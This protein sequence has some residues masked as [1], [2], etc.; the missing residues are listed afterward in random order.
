MFQNLSSFFKEFDY[1]NG[2]KIYKYDN[3]SLKMLQ[4][5]YQIALKNK[6]IH[7]SKTILKDGKI[8]D[9]ED[10]TRERG[11]VYWIDFGINIG[12]EFNSNHFGVVIKEFKYTALV[13][14]I[15]TIK[16]SD[17]SWKN[18]EN[19]VI[20]IGKIEGLPGK[21]EDSYAMVNQLKSLS[22]QRLTFY[23]DNITREQ[24]KDLKLNNIQLDLI[25]DAILQCVDKKRHCIGI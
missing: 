17:S 11:Y 7:E 10:L 8:C 12:S 13:V 23:R 24:F 3:Y 15:S 16:E 4:W 9:I 25:D 20:P 2:K 6:I 14:P 22:K 1:F 18:P 5:I 19:L 21:K